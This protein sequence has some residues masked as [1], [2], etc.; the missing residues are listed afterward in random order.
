MA[1]DSAITRF[2]GRLWSASLILLLFVGGGSLIVARSVSRRIRQLKEFSLRVAGGDF[3]PLEMPAGSDELD[4]LAHALN[5][6]AS[7]LDGTIRV[8]TDERN[9]SAAILRSMI[10]GVAVI[11]AQE[12]VLFSNRAFSQIL[13][14]GSDCRSKAAPSSRW[15][16]NPICSRSSNGRLRSARRSEA[17]LLSVSFGPEVSR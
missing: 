12:R 2:R 14:L 13:G 16:V 3:R 8:L 5:H 1:V 9:R 17:R 15:F 4:D 11:S 10:E 7:Q 6:T